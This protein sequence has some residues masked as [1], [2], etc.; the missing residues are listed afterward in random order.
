MPLVIFSGTPASGKTTNAEILAKYVKDTLGKKVYLF[1]EES[2]KLVKSDAYKDGWIEKQTRGTIKAECDRFLTTDVLVIVDSLNYIKGFRYELYCIAR[3][4]RTTH[5]VVYCTADV[6][7]RREWN[8]NRENKFTPELFEDLNNRFEEPNGRNRWDA[9]LY[10]VSQ[11]DTLPLEKICHGLY[12]Q[13]VKAPPNSATIP[14]V[15]SETNFVYELDKITQEI[16][17]TIRKF[18][19]SGTFVP[20]DSVA[21]PKADTRA[22]LVRKVTVAELGRIRRQFL[23]ISQLHPPKPAEMG[24][25]F[26]EYLNGCLAS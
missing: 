17:S 16:V 14:S 11:N 9:P 20:G 8:E 24:D 5:C 19:E 21:V 23:K 18:Q 15:I 1:N 22:K 25:V 4:L 12:N 3:S 13:N 2:L 26:V 6:D 7:T 10:T